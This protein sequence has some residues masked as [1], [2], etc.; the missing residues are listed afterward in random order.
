MNVMNRITWKAM[1]KNKLRTLVTIVGI[2]LSAAMFMAVTTMC[3][4]IWQ[5]LV[6]HEC[7]NNG[8][9]FI[10]I[11]V[12]TQEQLEML[13]HDDHITKL[14]VG[15]TLGYTTFE[16][17]PEDGASYETAVILAGD[18]A[19]YEM[20]SDELVHG[21]YPQNSGE[22][23]ITENVYQYLKKAGKPCEIGQTVTL[24]IAVELEGMEF[25]TSG[26][27]YS[28]EYKI[29]GIL[30]TFFKFHGDNFNLSSLL[31]YADGKE[32]P[33]L[34]YSSMVKTSPASHARTYISN[35]SQDTAYGQWFDL[36]LDMLGLYGDIK[37]ANYTVVIGG[38]AAV[39][40][41]IILIGSVSLIYNAF[42]ISVSERTKQFG[43]LCG[44]GATKKQI[45]KSVLFEA[46][47]LC[48][49][50]IPIGILCGY[51]GIWI[52][53]YF[54]GDAVDVMMQGSFGSTATL[55]ARFSWIAALIAA[56]VG[57]LSVYLSALIPARK[58]TKIAPVSAIRQS[59]EYVVPKKNV[60]IGRLSQKLWGIPGLLAK[61]YY[62]T[63]RK[64]YRSTVASLAVSIFLFITAASFAGE[65]QKVANSAVNTQN[66]DLMILKDTYY[67]IG[68]IRNMDFVDN[69]AW[70]SRNYDYGT[71]P[72]ESMLS[73]QYRK[74]A[75]EQTV[76]DRFYPSY[77][78]IL[79]LE[80]EVFLD[81]LTEHGI[82]PEQYFQKDTPAALVCD[83]DYTHYQYDG[84]GKGTRLSYEIPV[85][86]ED[87]K[88]I[89]IYSRGVPAEVRRYYA[90][91][92]IHT[93]YSISEIT[94]HGNWV[95]ELVPYELNQGLMYMLEEEAE[96]VLVVQENV[97]NKTY[98]SYYPYDPETNT[99]T[100]ELIFTQETKTPDLCLG[101]RISELPFGVPNHGRSSYN[102][103]ML[104]L[105]MSCMPQSDLRL[106]VTVSDYEAFLK[107]AREKNLSYFDYLNSE[108]M[109][110][111]VLFLINVFSN[112]FI[113]LISLICVC[114][115]FNT[116]TTNIL[117]RRKDFG[118][119]RSVGMKNR[120]LYSMM[121]YECMQYGI[122][123]LLYGLP[124]GLLAGYGVYL[125]TD[126]A[127]NL[128]YTAPWN[129]LLIASV[130][131]IAVVFISMLYGIS[132]IKRVD[133]IEAIRSE[134]I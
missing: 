27:D 85:L 66:F 74:L 79:Y 98:E 90:E 38:L 8:D 73:E 29:V 101:E 103:I 59:G 2:I 47:T 45:R 1:W 87:V 102:C 100:E 124:L 117:L 112:G 18:E 60:K 108:R 88:D 28:K 14:G 16:L 10:K 17:M 134:N 110:R 111:T 40:M 76:F 131:V 118:V 122:L 116:V 64:K 35:N 105:P 21:M 9:C 95:I 115:V 52:T 68:D 57:M 78:E 99:R 91:N 25:P 56:L 26:E 43:L 62:S 77:V 33:A 48:V 53:L 104:L 20:I 114:N 54:V 58:A 133:P 129:A 41:G 123:S 92:S 42:S 22:I 109:F 80:D 89:P 39:L 37:Y 24:D 3:V 6:D 120:E 86:A 121:G 128:S 44:I 83:L 5:F 30:Q 69:S 127:E 72:D 71:A 46:S 36:N 15:K 75:R 31:T 113:I 106:S 93:D 94:M 132:R 119:L 126:Q 13:R 65:L 12:Q 7:I 96:Y 67:D 81:Y 49:L 97:G 4:S 32:A 23:A 51:A 55:S 63:S 50:G 11:F 19:F 130:C 107:F 34:W 61:K 84:N 125:I 70:V 82:A